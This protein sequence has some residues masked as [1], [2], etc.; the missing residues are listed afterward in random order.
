VTEPRQFLIDPSAWGT[1]R[2]N[3]TWRIPPGERYKGLIA[4]S[5]GHDAVFHLRQRIGGRNWTHADYAQ[6]ARI[7]TKV[8]GSMLRGERLPTLE[9]LAVATNVFGVAV[10]PS[11]SAIDKHLQA[12]A[13]AIKSQRAAAGTPTAQTTGPARRGPEGLMA[14]LDGYRTLAAL[15]SRPAAV[16]EEPLDEE[17][18][19]SRDALAEHARPILEEAARTLT[20]ST[21]CTVEVDLARR[22]YLHPVSVSGTTSAESSDLLIRL[23]ST[24][25]EDVHA[26]GYALLD[27]HAVLAVEDEAMGRPARVLVLATEPDLDF[28]DTENP[29]AAPDIRFVAQSKTVTWHGAHATLA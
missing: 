6:N 4:A 24:W 1:D 9:D 18:E 21:T 27:G 11:R 10:L 16:E 28:H 26:R 23:P 14:Y 19:R 15:G 22:A 29:P 7:T 2:E 5:I 3:I 8:V 17:E 12:T 13:A 25:M 20:D